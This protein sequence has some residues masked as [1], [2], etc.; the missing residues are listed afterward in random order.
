MTTGKGNESIVRQE[1]SWKKVEL[2]SRRG[3][4]ICNT[5]YNP[6]GLNKISHFSRSGRASS[7]L[8]MKNLNSF[9]EENTESE[10]FYVEGNSE[11][12]NIVV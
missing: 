2:I 6:V 1:N 9:F 8:P 5:T 3:K 4:F 10:T 11:N 12:Y 7:R